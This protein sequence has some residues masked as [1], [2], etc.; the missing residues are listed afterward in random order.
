[1]KVRF[2]LRSWVEPLRGPAR[3]TGH[4]LAHAGRWSLRWLR[5]LALAPV[6]G[7]RWLLG[8]WARLSRFY[9]HLI[10]NLLIGI[11]IAVVLHAYHSSPL[12]HP[13][14]DAA[15]DWTMRM[16]RGTEPA[17]GTR[18]IAFI[19]IDDASWRQ[20][21]EPLLTPR[22]RLAVLLRHAVDGGARAIVLDIDLVHPEDGDAA[23]QA[24]L[25]RWLPN[26]DGEAPDRPP[27]LLARDL[28]LPARGSPALPQERATPFDALVA[29]APGIHWGAPLFE[30]DADGKIRRWQLWTATC[31]VDGQPRVRPSMQLL[32]A[33]LLDGSAADRADLSR[34]LAGF[35]P[36]GCDPAHGRSG[37]DGHGHEAQG[38]ALAQGGDR[39][40]GQ[41]SHPG[42]HHQAQAAA[43]PHGEEGVT[44]TLGDREI[45]LRPYGTAARVVYR[46]PWHTGPGQA[47][48]EVPAAGG[49]VPVLSVRPAASV[50]AATDP[51]SAEWLRGHVAIIGGSHQ[52]TGDIHM[53]PIGWMPGSLILANAV[54]SLGH[55]G[56]LRTPSL[57][58]MVLVETCLILTMSL[59]FARFRSLPGS[60]LSG[61]AVLLVLLPASLLLFRYGTWLSFAVP[62]I[63]ILLHK[64][65]AEIEESVG[66]AH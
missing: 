16:V 38:Q 23:L 28:R 40:A 56:E 6:V 30:L 59:L 32:L 54:Q 15:I 60:L 48:H 46:E 24:V 33:A 41:A 53:T 27:L 2:R 29:Q 55:Y 10:V 65:I 17:A 45:Q 9:R 44:L 25:A 21:G 1:M 22:D 4:G 57:G 58:M 5:R 26:A 64:L 61:L 37:H 20:W 39:I 31:G 34:R 49:S 3:A 66:N 47:R 51:R 8:G 62:L 52:E 36:A 18:P 13:L 50:A 19:D 63:A 35:V 12:L 11:A 14:D 42:D 7:V 43:D